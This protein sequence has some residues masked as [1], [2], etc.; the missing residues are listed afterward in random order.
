MICDERGTFHKDTLK[1]FKHMKDEESKSIFKYSAIQRIMTIIYKAFDYADQRSAQIAKLTEK[2]ADPLFWRGSLTK[3]ALSLAW[4]EY[5]LKWNI[6]SHSADCVK[7]VGYL[8]D[9]II[10]VNSRYAL[11]KIYVGQLFHFF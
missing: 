7:E 1:W 8:Y 6:I 4:V 3:T 11:Y 2:C 9:V 10:F 5:G